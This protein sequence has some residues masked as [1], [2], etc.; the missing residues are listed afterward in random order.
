MVRSDKKGF[1]LIELMIVVAIIGVLAAVAIPAYSGYVK[2]A[3][4]SEVTNAMGALGSAAVEIYQASGNMPDLVTTIAQID[5]SFGITIP[6]TYVSTVQ[7]DG[8]DV[9][10]DPAGD[11]ETG[12]ITVT[13]NDVIGS[14]F[15]DRTIELTVRQGTRG[16]WSGGTNP[17][18]SGY[19][20]KN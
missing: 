5:N 13:F 10:A 11:L 1:T 14:E 20:P 8:Q 18:P 3:R 9:D 2:R 19:I 7:F 4:M 12:V 16:S 6:P 17:V 15:L